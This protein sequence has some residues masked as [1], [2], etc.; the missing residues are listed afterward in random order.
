M[1]NFVML[2]LAMALSLFSNS[3]WYA[4]YNHIPGI[5]LPP[6]ADQQ[7]GAAILWVC[8]DFWAIPS[9]IVVIRR[10]ILNEGSMNA[11]VDKILN[12]GSS[13]FR[14]GPPPLPPKLPAASSG[15]AGTQPGQTPP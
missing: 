4:P 6:F 13:R 5:T 2:M 3:S 9:L 11:A 7:M 8:G 10:I 14:W 1:T 15:G 12:R